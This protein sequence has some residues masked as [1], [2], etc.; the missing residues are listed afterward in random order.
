MRHMLEGDNLGLVSVRQVKTGKTWQHITVSNAMVE[1]TYLSNKTSEIDY[2][3]PLY[4]YNENANGDAYKTENVKPAFRRWIDNYYG[5]KLSPENIIGY[6]YAVLHS[7]DYRRRYADLLRM[8]FPRVPFVKDIKEFNRLAKIG[9]KLIN[10]HLLK[11]DKLKLS[12]QLHGE[13]L[14]VKKVKYTRPAAN[15]S[16]ITT[17]I[18]LLCRRKF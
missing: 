11:D 7:P 5:K 16:L 14:Q 10:A 18:L 9:D 4:L 12:L 3:F 1:S 8:D 6:I 17:P 15:C 2:L 13:N